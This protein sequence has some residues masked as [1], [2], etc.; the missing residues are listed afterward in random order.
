MQLTEIT[1]EIGRLEIGLSGAHMRISDL[2]REVMGHI[3]LLHRRHGSG[4]GRKPP[5][6]QIAAMGTVALTSILGLVS[7]EKAA[8][9][10]RALLH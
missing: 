9:I 4:H 5:W 7:P 3:V 10:L 2:R 8:A 1:R 6:L